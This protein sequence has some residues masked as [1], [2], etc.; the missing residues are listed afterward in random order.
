MVNLL[1]AGRIISCDRRI[2]GS[3]R[4]MP[5]CFTTGEAAGLAAALAA[6]GDRDVHTVD[7][8]LLRDKL[9]QYGAYFK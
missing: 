8:G 5:N 4:V 2:L 1:C 7:V 6:S 3:V 9:R